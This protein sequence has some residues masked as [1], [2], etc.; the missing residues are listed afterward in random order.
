MYTAGRHDTRSLLQLKLPT[1]KYHAQQES[2][3]TPG[4]KQMPLKLL[5]AQ[6]YCVAIELDRRLGHPS[7]PSQFRL[8]TRRRP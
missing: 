7:I 4:E 1:R 5:G 2:K 6:R 8:L 3:Q